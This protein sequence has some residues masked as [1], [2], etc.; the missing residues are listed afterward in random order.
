MLLSQLDYALRD[1][2]AL[3]VNNS[4]TKSKDR[5]KN[6]DFFLKLLIDNL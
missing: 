1:L 5:K 6:E 2:P 4:L 3:F